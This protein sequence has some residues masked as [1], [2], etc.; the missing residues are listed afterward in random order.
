MAAAFAAA[1]VATA[2]AS[3]DAHEQAISFKSAA[4]ASSRAA[5][6]FQQ[7]E[8]E[9]AV[10]TAKK[11]SKE[12]AAVR[13]SNVQAAKDA[14]AFVN[15]R[16]VAAGAHGPGITAVPPVGGMAYYG[17]RMPCASFLQTGFCIFGQNCWMAHGFAPGPAPP[18]LGMFGQPHAEI[19]PKNKTHKKK[20]D[21]V[22]TKD[23]KPKKHK[24][25]KEHHKASKSHRGSSKERRKRKHARSLSESSEEGEQEDEQGDKAKKEVHKKAEENIQVQQKDEGTQRKLLLSVSS[26]RCRSRSDSLSSEGPLRLQPRFAGPPQL[27]ASTAALATNTSIPAVGGAL[28]TATRRRPGAEGHGP[29]PLAFETVSQNTVVMLSP[30]A[31]PQN[32]ESEQ[33]RDWVEEEVAWRQETRSRR[34]RIG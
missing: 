3:A 9:E 24:D 5:Q 4:D 16:N 27:A 11:A 7:V 18:F 33:D 32:D 22:K 15:A 13:A 6:L 31:S 23:K 21:K 17:N 19:S 20:K 8:D 25:K 2:R 28:S 14:A 26:N 10:Q 30:E 12:A 1:A 29:R 34:Q